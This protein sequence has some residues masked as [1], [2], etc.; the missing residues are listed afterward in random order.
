MADSE[1]HR[2]GGS[3]AEAEKEPLR[4]RA[5]QEAI[6]NTSNSKKAR[7]EQEEQVRAARLAAQALQPAGKAKDVTNRHRNNRSRR[8][9]A[10]ESDPTAGGDS[11]LDRWQPNNDR[12]MPPSSPA[13]AD[14]PA[15]AARPVATSAQLDASQQA[16][17]GRT[18]SEDETQLVKSRDPKKSKRKQDKPAKEKGRLKDKRGDADSDKA[19][20]KRKEGKSRKPDAVQDRPLDQD[21]SQSQDTKASTAVDASTRQT[22][23]KQGS[24]RPTEPAEELEAG[25]SPRSHRSS[26]PRGLSEQSPEIHHTGTPHSSAKDEHVPIRCYDNGQ[27]ETSAGWKHA[28]AARMRQPEPT[29][30]G[31]GGEV[32]GNQDRSRGHEPMQ[33]EALQ[34]HASTGARR[35]LERSVTNR[36]QRDEREDEARPSGLH[37]RSERPQLSRKQESEKSR[38]CLVEIPRESRRRQSPSPGRQLKRLSRP[39]PVPQDKRQDSVPKPRDIE[40]VDRA[41][42]RNR[43]RESPA[44][45]VAQRRRSVDRE[46]VGVRARQPK[47]FADGRRQHSADRDE[48]LRDR[49][50][51]QS[52]AERRQDYV[53]EQMEQRYNG[54]ETRN[55]R[56]PERERYGQG[57]EL[58]KRYPDKAAA[59]V[60][61]RSPERGPSPR[62][63]AR[64]PQP[65]LARRP[66]VDST[67]AHR[68]RSPMQR[69]R[70]PSG[71]RDRSPDEDIRLRRADAQ[72]DRADGRFAEAAARSK[73]RSYN[74]FPPD[75]YHAR[76]SRDFANNR[77]EREIREQPEQHRAGPDE[78]SRQRP[79]HEHSHPGPEIERFAGR[80]K[81]MGRG[82]WNG[83]GGRGDFQPFGMPFP[84]GPRGFTGFP[85][86]PRGFAD[87]RMLPRGMG[88][89][90]GFMGPDVALPEDMR[91]NKGMPRD[92]RPGPQLKPRR[93]EMP[94]PRTDRPHPDRK[95]HDDSEAG[96]S[97]DILSTPHSSGKTSRARLEHAGTSVPLEDKAVPRGPPR[98]QLQ[99]QQLLLA[100]AHVSRALAG[101]DLYR[102]CMAILGQVDQTMAAPDVEAQ[103]DN[104]QTAEDGV[105]SVQPCHEEFKACLDQHQK[106]V[107]EGRAVPSHH[108]FF[109]VPSQE[110]AVYL[111]SCSASTN[112]WSTLGA[113]ESTQK[114]V[115]LPTA[116]Q[117][118]VKYVGCPA[119]AGEA[120]KELEKE[121]HLA[122]RIN[123]QLGEAR[124]IGQ[125]DN[126]PSAA[127][128]AASDLPDLSHVA[129]V[130]AIEEDAVMYSSEDDDPASGPLQD[131][132]DAE[133]TQASDMQAWHPKAKDSLTLDH[134]T[135]AEVIKDATEECGA[136]EQPECKRN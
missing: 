116:P 21:Q 94:R 13:R 41:D 28:V 39:D 44:P 89:P 14:P 74:D 62:R 57:A 136:A 125:I 27:R 37:E 54:H 51:Q 36:R 46:K 58:E 35:E 73:G 66:P 65:S 119:E 17:K 29:E 15:A 69:A 135:P 102:E 126:P 131:M 129:A 114:A 11:D 47:P 99:A 124:S 40:Q 1:Q 26:D 133:Y 81:S 43:R 10:A 68:D 33:S 2:R 75:D 127:E 4:K 45:D 25:L 80:G 22:S 32:H 104:T 67:P 112:L 103:V 6:P 71:Y 86:G 31:Y 134:G 128:F 60:L 72:A 132:A 111:S 113:M 77:D 30:R 115:Q 101:E 92:S 18:A 63:L 70:S 78:H 42:V 16:H 56:S 79:L 50:R 105:A 3:R 121:V 90:P 48:P 9:L 55:S 88:A 93:E 118:L 34:D 98:L 20:K 108:G 38:D 96:R 122:E 12:W 19:K 23:S 61:G 91:V 24:K 123:G 120:T 82:G 100:T 109:T 7:W 130:E 85:P 49:R 107:M 110:L 76:A 84:G 87:A 106:P 52:P 53:R 8:E 97:Q 5:A 95:D 117:T 83:P 64:G 59:A